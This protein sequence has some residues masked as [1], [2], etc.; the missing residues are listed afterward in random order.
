M[1][2]LFFSL[3]V[4]EWLKILAVGLVLVG[5]CGEVLASL[6][7]DKRGIWR[8]VLIVG[9][10]MQLAFIPWDL[11]ETAGLR[12]ETE[13]LKA[14]NNRL[15]KAAIARRVTPD[16]QRRIGS[17]RGGS[18]KILFVKNDEEA[19]QLAAELRDAL[20]AFGWKIDDLRH[21]TPDEQDWAPLIGSHITTSRTDTSGMA[22]P[23]PR[24]DFFRELLGGGPGDY[25]TSE[26]PDNSFILKIGHNKA[27][28]W[29]WSP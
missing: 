28:L 19:S 13:V 6:K 23:T 29:D 21:M 1:R 7:D 12:K 11:K 16:L 26:L 4:L 27:I 15:Y 8:A 9:L 3:S 10:A 20:V 5:V 2:A 14:S 17:F 18:A 25:G 24:I 22:R